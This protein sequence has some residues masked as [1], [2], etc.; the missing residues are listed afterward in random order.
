MEKDRQFDTGQIK[1][2][3]KKSYSVINRLIL[4]AEL[5]LKNGQNQIQHLWW[6]IK[7]E[8]YVVM[9]TFSFYGHS[10]SEN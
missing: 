1:I 9:I 7:I 2:G 4:D 6:T 5:L 3:F 10:D 8:F